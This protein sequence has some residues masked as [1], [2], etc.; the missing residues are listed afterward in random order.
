MPTWMQVGVQTIKSS[1][2]HILLSYVSLPLR[3]PPTSGRPPATS[4]FLGI[5]YQLSN[6]HGKMTLDSYSRRSL[7]WSC[8]YSE[9]LTMVWA[10]KAGSGAGSGVLIG[11]DWVICPKRVGQ[12]SGLRSVPPEP[13]GDWERCHSPKENRYVLLLIQRNNSG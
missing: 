12:G 5:F 10:E 8:T 9:S 13:H 1:P 6:P 4:T 3:W 7:T 11:L 2:T